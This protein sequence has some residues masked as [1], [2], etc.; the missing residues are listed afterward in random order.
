M[1]G[2]PP[3]VIPGLTEAKIAEDFAF[4]EAAY[5]YRLAQSPSSP[6]HAR[7]GELYQEMQ[8]VRQRVIDEYK[9]THPEPPSPPSPPAEVRFIS[10]PVAVEFDPNLRRVTC[11]RRLT[12][13]NQ[14]VNLTLSDGGNGVTTRYTVQPGSSGGYIVSILDT[15]RR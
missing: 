5:Q 10:E 15:P 9:S 3:G 6:N 11:D 4:K 8:R 2:P 7:M 14:L 1:F 13:N 12:T